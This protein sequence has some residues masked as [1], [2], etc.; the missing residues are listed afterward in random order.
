MGGFNDER[1]GRIPA[2]LARQVMSWMRFQYPIRRADE[3][4][5]SNGCNVFASRFIERNGSKADGD[6]ESNF[7]ELCWI[8]MCRNQKKS[9]IIMCIAL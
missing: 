9:L 3:K 2:G 4:V 5:H 1:Y 8:I 6:A 7:Q